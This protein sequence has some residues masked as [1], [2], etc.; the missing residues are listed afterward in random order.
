MPFSKWKEVGEREALPN[1]YPGTIREAG[2]YLL[3][4]LGA[5]RAWNLLGRRNIGNIKPSIDP[6]RGYLAPEAGDAFFP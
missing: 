4:L 3:H 1:P 5:E 6:F 2:S